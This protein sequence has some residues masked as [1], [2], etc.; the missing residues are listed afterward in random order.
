MS[1]YKASFTA[2]GLSDHIKRGDEIEI[3][4]NRG[5]LWRMMVDDVRPA[6]GKIPVPGEPY[7]L[8]GSATLFSEGD[9]G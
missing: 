3:T 9:P 8:Y 6:P 5:A 4:D 2:P 7:V 1:I